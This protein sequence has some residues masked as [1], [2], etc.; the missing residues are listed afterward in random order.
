MTILQI[1]TITPEEKYIEIIIMNTNHLDI[2]K[3]A[4]KICLI[5]LNMK[6]IK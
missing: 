4:Q 2:V 3:Y 6:S 1:I 5:R